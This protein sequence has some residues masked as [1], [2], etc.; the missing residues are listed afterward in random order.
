MVPGIDRISGALNTLFRVII[1]DR[2]EKAHSLHPRK[3]SRHRVS[4]LLGVGTCSMLWLGALSLN[5][6]ASLTI[7]FRGKCSARFHF[8][9]H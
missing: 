5:P 8:V 2:H 7:A 6:S 9:P 4:H 1:F 3:I